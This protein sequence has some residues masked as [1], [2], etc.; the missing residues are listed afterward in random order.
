MTADRQQRRRI[1]DHRQPLRII[2]L[3]HGND[4]DAELFRGLD[5]ALG[6]GA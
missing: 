4:H 5:L 6:L 2:R 1:V 3:A